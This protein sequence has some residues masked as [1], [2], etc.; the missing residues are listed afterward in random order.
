MAAT[1]WREAKTVQQVRS[2]GHGRSPLDSLLPTLGI[3]LSLLDEFE[4]RYGDEPLPLPPS[5]QRVV[6]LLALRGRWVPRSVVGSTLWADSSDEVG[7]RNLRS[8]LWRVNRPGLPLIEA[9]RSHLRLGRHV[10]VDLHEAMDRARRLVAGWIDGAS[11]VDERLLGSLTAD[12]LPDWD[13]DWLMGE[14]ERIRHVRLHALE[15]LCDLLTT[16]GRHGEA[17]EAGIAAVRG[18]PLRESARRTLI[19][20]HLAEG[21]VVEAVRQYSAYRQLLTDELGILPSVQLQELVALA[22]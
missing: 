19:R 8:A 20:A 9:G 10:V 15:S 12:L 3:R 11:L 14:R 16:A 5:G 7:A 18:E 4:V 2:K 22:R 21:N 6:A 1:G 13:D 17:V